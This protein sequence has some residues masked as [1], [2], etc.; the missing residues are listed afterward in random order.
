[1]EPPDE[2]DK[3]YGQFRPRQVSSH[4]PASTSY[5]SSLSSQGNSGPGSGSDQF[6]FTRSYRSPFQP[7]RSSSQQARYSRALIGPAPKALR[8][9][10]SKALE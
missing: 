1:M 8:S 9:H 10:W 7:V 5:F 6:S 4:S 3:Y 2:F